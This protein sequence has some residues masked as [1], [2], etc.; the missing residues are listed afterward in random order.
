MTRW[1]AQSDQRS[2]RGTLRSSARAGVVV[3][4]AFAVMGLFSGC[5]ALRP[6]D[7]MPARYMP[8]SLKG[9][10]RS[11]RKTINLSL[12]SQ[13]QPPEYLI[14]SGD[15]LGI[16]I[17]KVLGQ[18]D[19]LPPVH[20]S[21]NKQV[22][23]TMGYPIPVRADGTISLPLLSVPVQVAGLD[24]W[25]FKGSLWCTESCTRCRTTQGYDCN[26]ARIQSKPITFNFYYTASRHHRPSKARIGITNEG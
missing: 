14:D 3:S 12:L 15:V 22:P 8:E 21:E 7:G 25:I 24:L 9:P 1:T 26:C 16:Y 5:A 19:A 4:V 20:F 17:D 2:H 23:P 6:L 11:G 13:T 10:S 18:P